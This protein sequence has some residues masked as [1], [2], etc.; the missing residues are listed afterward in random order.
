MRQASTASRRD[1]LRMAGALGSGMAVA[2]CFPFDTLP[3]PKAQALA[4]ADRAGAV[5]KADVE[6]VLP[7]EDLMREHGVLRRILLIY[8]EAIRRLEKELELDPA[9]VASSATLVRRFIEEYHE[10]SEEDHVFPH[11]EQ[12]GKLVELVAT[13]KEQHQAGRRVTASILELATAASLASDTNRQALVTRLRQFIRM[14]EPH[15]AREDT[16]LLPAF[17]SVVTPRQYDAY[18]ELFEEQEH[19]LFGPQGFE[20]IVA[21]VGDLEARLDLADLRQF[22]PR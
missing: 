2:A 21:Q 4:A 11:F 3:G 16:V 15:A 8:G 7:V 12:A 18:S 5:V 6:E 13:L 20:D 1:F 17:R 22:T 10:K 9:V 19:R 14:Y